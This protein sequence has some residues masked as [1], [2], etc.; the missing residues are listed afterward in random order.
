MMTTSNEIFIAA[1][2]GRIFDLAARTERWPQILPHYR[3][4]RVL[5]GDEVQRVVEMSAWRDFI[6][7]RWVAQQWNDEGGPHIRFRH[8]AGW[9]KGMEVQWQ[10]ERDR[11]GTRVRILHEL[12]FQFPFARE[13][14][15]RYVVGDFFVHNIAAKTLA[16]MKDLAER[17]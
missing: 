11:E 7:V 13:F 10:F 8:I 9:T 3:S 15:G 5:E 12:D 4:V 6:P 16:R 17:G 1:P 14:L 2:P